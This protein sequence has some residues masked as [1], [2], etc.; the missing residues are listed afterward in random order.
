MFLNEQTPFIHSILAEKILWWKENGQR[1]GSLKMFV[2]LYDSSWDLSTIASDYF[3]DYIDITFLKKQPRFDVHVKRNSP[4]NNNC[5]CMKRW[6]K[7]CSWNS[8]DSVW[9]KKRTHRYHRNSERTI[10]FC[11]AKSSIC[12]FLNVPSLSIDSKLTANLFYH[13][14]DHSSEAR[15][16]MS[17]SGNGFFDG[18]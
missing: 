11:S 8:W 5:I 16:D 10:P 7:T 12:L 9:C 4:L 6:A 13:C 15:L 18:C 2:S 14:F 17:F 1:V 3:L